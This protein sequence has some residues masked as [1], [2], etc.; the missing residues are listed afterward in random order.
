M[1]NFRES[2]G[3]NVSISPVDSLT[4]R[5]LPSTETTVPLISLVVLLDEPWIRSVVFLAVGGNCCATRKPLIMNAM[6]EPFRILLVVVVMFPFSLLSD[7]ISLTLQRQPP[8]T[9]SRMLLPPGRSTRG[10]GPIFR[11]FTSL[12]HVSHLR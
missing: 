12:Y 7:V 9:H 11:C 8:R 5:V 6:Q 10:P 3:L 2:G 1:S 4:T